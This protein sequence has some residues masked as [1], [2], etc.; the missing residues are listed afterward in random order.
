MQVPSFHALD[1][2][3]PTPCDLTGRVQG[4]IYQT[5]V[6]VRD[7]AC[8]PL[9]G[10]LTRLSPAAAP[11]PAAGRWPLRGAVHPPARPCLAPAAQPRH[12]PTCHACRG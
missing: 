10:G 7:T 11:S 3:L 1:A 9:P 4:G 12:R 6:G 5:S 2:R 8:T